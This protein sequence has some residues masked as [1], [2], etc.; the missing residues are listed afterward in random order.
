[1]KINQL[2]L[3][4]CA[5]YVLQRNENKAMLQSEDF[6]NAVMAQA[7]KGDRAQFSKL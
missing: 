3:I 2:I 6:I 7:T 1:M 4:I 5:V